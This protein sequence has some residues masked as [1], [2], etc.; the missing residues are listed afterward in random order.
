MPAV[1]A[2]V[3]AANQGYATAQCCLG[4]CYYNGEGVTQNKTEAARLYKLAA[5]Q[6][7]AR[8]QCNLGWCYKYGEG[9]AKDIKEAVRLYK[10][11][12]DQGHAR[13]QC[14]LGVCYDKGEGVT[15]SKTEAIRLFRLAAAQGDEYAKKALKR[16]GLLT[17]EKLHRHFVFRVGKRRRFIQNKNE[18][19]FEHD[20]SNGNPLLFSARKIHALASDDGIHALRELRQNVVALCVVEH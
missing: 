10:L 11:A 3:M 2:G 9:V 16:L 1:N 5:D 8:A 17:C 7:Y 6:G 18:R 14:N 4:V 13:A 20:A 12:A 15:Q 19:I